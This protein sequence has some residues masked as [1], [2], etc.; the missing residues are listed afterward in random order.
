MS[1]LD[2]VCVYVCVCLKSEEEEEEGEE[3]MGGREKGKTLFVA[4]RWSGV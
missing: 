3:E 2:S 1:R 4:N